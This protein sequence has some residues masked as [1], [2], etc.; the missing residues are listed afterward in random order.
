MEK[1]EMKLL[2]PKNKG[3]SLIEPEFIKEKR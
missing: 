1:K 2:E 3:L